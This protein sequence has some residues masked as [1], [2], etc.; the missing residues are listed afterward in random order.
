LQKGAAVLPGLAGSDSYLHL[1]TQQFTR[2][3]IDSAL[4]NL[5]FI[6]EEIRYQVSPAGLRALEN[7]RGIGMNMMVKYRKRVAAARAASGS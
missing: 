4:R 2:G 5:G 1:Q 7:N 3:A 6:A